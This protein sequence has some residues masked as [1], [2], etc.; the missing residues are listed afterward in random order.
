MDAFPAD[1]DGDQDI[2]IV[3]IAQGGLKVGWFENLGRGTFTEHVLTSDFQGA[4]CYVADLD[5]DND[6]D[7]IVSSKAEGQ[8]KVWITEIEDENS[9]SASN[10]TWYSI[11]LISLVVIRKIKRQ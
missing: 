4:R 1:I 11:W 7:I 2:D 10:F 6:N 5:N 9:I 3:G 8:I